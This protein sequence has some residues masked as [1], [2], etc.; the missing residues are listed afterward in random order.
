MFDKIKEIE[1]NITDTKKLYVMAEK[2]LQES[3]ESAVET[4]DFG[5][6]RF[7]AFRVLFEK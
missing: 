6:A 1:D 2:S 5:C 7:E 4:K 3:L